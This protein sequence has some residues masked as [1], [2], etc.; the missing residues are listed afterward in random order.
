MT[1]K[2]DKDEDIYMKDAI[3]TIFPLFLGA[4][5]G[6]VSY[7]ISL[8]GYRDPIGIIV[9]VIFIYIHKFILPKFEIE[10]ASKDWAVISFLTLT[11][12]YISWTFLL[13]A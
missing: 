6:M 7:L 9:L 8:E 4:I 10:L 1:E 12:W 3:K 5:A 13:N 2:N 11:T